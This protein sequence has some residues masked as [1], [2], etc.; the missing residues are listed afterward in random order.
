MDGSTPLKNSTLGSTLNAVCLALAEAQ[1][2]SGVDLNRRMVEEDLPND[3]F[4]VAVEAGWISEPTA[5]FATT[6]T[7]ELGFYQVERKYREDFIGLIQTSLIS[8][9]EIAGNELGEPFETVAPI[10][11]EEY[12]RSKVRETSSDERR[13]LVEDYL[14]L[15]K[16]PTYGNDYEMRELHHLS[17]VRREVFDR[18]RRGKIPNNSKP[19]KRIL[20]LLQKNLPH[21]DPR[22]LPP[23]EREL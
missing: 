13:L 2:S 17:S 12:H 1:T 15:H 7:V 23:R 3:L 16:H 11:N 6:E 8:L 4:M 14:R 5:P 10:W 9:R 18:W 19:G 20:A 22:Y 21:R